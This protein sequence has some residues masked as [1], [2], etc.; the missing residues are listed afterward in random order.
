MATYL[1]ALIGRRIAGDHIEHVTEPLRDGACKVQGNP[2][3][4]HHHR[5]PR[6]GEITGRL[7]DLDARDVAS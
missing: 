3:P 5:A 1:G 7:L 6:G 4:G 2:G